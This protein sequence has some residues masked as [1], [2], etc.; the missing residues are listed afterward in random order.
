MPMPTPADRLRDL[1]AR[2]GL[3]L[4]PGCH[5]ALSAKLAEQAGFPT[6]FMSG[7]AGWACPT[8]A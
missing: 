1:L 5:D 4:M 2:P 3:L 8:P 7:F 6:A